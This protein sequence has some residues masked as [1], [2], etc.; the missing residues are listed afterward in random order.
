ML[1]RIL[2]YLG[3]LSSHQQ[4]NPVKV[5]PPLAKLCGSAHDF[6]PSIFHR[7][8]VTIDTEISLS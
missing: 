4:K 3:P 7:I 1:A 2:S 6:H 8:E 5:G